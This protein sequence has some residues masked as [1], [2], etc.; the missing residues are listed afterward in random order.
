MV[1][2]IPENTVRLFLDNFNR[3]AD[4]DGILPTNLLGN[5]LRRENDI[6][7]KSDNL[8]IFNF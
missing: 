8:Y 7:F 3:M 4:R 1:E 5:L 2:L 6:Y